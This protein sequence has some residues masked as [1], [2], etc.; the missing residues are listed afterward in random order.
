MNG[1]GAEAFTKGIMGGYGFVDKMKNSAQQREN[2]ELIMEKSRMQ[3][4]YASKIDANLDREAQQLQAQQEASLRTN[5]IQTQAKQQ[6]IGIQETQN[7]T[8]QKIH[9]QDQE[10]AQ[11]KQANKTRDGNGGKLVMNQLALTDTLEGRRKALPSTISQLEANPAVLQAYG[12]QNVK[13]ART[14]DPMNPKDIQYMEGMMTDTF[15]MDPNQMS[16]TEWATARNKLFEKVFF[17][18]SECHIKDF[19]VAV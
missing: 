1:Q 17:K 2:N 19:R 10:I 14:M 11:L 5:Q 13:S 15:G 9:Q 18:E 16:T 4:K 6:G 8:Q 12:I 3:N 7:E